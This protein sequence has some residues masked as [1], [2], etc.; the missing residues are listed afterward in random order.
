MLKINLFKKKKKT[1][2]HTHT[3]NTHHRPHTPHAYTTHTSHTPHTN[4]HTPHTHTFTQTYTHTP[5]THTHTPHTHIFTH[6]S[7]THTHTHPTHH[8][9]TPHNVI[10]KK[11]TLLT[12]RGPCKPT[13]TTIH[14]HFFSTIGFWRRFITHRH[15]SLFFGLCLLY[16]FLK[17]FK[18]RFG[19]WL[20]FRL[21]VKTDLRWWTH[22]IELFS[23]AG[24]HRNT[25]LVWTSAWERIS[26]CLKQETSYGK[27]KNKEETQ[28][29][30]VFWSDWFH[31]SFCGFLALICGLF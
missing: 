23:V 28:K 4:T 8:T 30:R 29:K 31:G 1:H 25:R 11:G 12:S 24:N 21:Q 18:T 10:W 3:N 20:C 26:P 2:T 5:Y 13:V 19:S 22:W 27:F 14:M 16:N 15:H 9:H 17:H 7:H 6:T